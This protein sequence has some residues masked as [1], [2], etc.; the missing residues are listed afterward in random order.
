MIVE[1]ELFIVNSVS[2][3]HLFVFVFVFVFVFA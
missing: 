1:K 3:L 2:Y